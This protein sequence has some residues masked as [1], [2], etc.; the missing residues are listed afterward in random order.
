MK[1][2]LNDGMQRFPKQCFIPSI[3]FYQ[4]QGILIALGNVV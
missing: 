1:D 3:W 4:L 2:R